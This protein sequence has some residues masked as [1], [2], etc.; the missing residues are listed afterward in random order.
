[1]S[2]FVRR[3]A[4]W[5]LFA[6]RDVPAALFTREEALAIG[7]QV[8]GFMTA[9][10][11][12]LSLSSSV[13]GLTLFADNEILGGEDS[14]GRSIEF[15]ELFDRR[16]VTLGTN[17][18]DEASLL[19]MVAKAEALAGGLRVEGRRPKP[20]DPLR[21]P[22]PVNAALWAESSIALTT[23]EA[24]LAAIDT[25]LTAIQRAGLTGAG[26]LSGRPSTAA[27]L[28]K[29]GHYEYGRWSRCEYSLTVRTPDGTGS[30]WAYWEGE[31]WSKLDVSVLTARAIDLA[32]RSQNPV[33]VEPGR[34]TVILMPEAC[35]ALVSLIATAFNGAVLSGLKTDEGGLPF[36]KVGGGNKIGRRVL[37]ERVSLSADPMDPEGGFFPFGYSYGRITQFVPVTWVERGVLKVL[38]YPTR[39]T[40]AALALDQLN[41]PGRLR[42][43]GGPTSVEKMIASTPR[44]ILV[45]RISDADPVVKQNL[46]TT[47]TTRDGTFLIESG[48]ITKPVKNMRFEDSPMFFLNN[49][50]A[51]GP[52]QRVQFGNVMPAIKVRDF[53]FTSL[54]DAV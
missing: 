45:N 26:Y 35:G 38:S 14:V 25:S 6:E 4:P 39:A 2:R 7:Q 22:A 24:R 32:A 36:S 29:A 8:E 19:Q 27:I 50:E 37:D 41:N 23:A 42:M 16:Q 31:D 11:E 43:A 48:K 51:I 17:Q 33:A 10:D 28:T 5:S 18:I 3:G 1:M 12:S 15:A 54:T 49:L 9:P 34:Y 30:G 52:A 44:G 53:A 40:A 21:S 47:G 20:R 46:L 13:S